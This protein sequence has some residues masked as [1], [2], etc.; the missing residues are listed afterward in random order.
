MYQKKKKKRMKELK[1]SLK[2]AE[3]ANQIEKE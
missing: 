2:E 3:I 1:E